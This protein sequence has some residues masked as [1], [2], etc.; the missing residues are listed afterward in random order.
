MSTT[1]ILPSYSD[2]EDVLQSVTTYNPAQVHGLMC[3]LLCTLPEQTNTS[4]EKLLFGNKIPQDHELLIELYEKSFEQ[5]NSFSFDF[6]LLLP[7]EDVDINDR[8]EA[9]GLWCQGFLTGL[10]HGKV[11]LKNREPGDVTETL[12]D[13]LE[14]SQVSYGELTDDNEDETAY[15]ELVEYVRLGALMIFQD[16]KANSPQEQSNQNN[17]LH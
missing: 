2:I 11:P 14:I 15:L 8:V 13:F 6:I 1:P 9:L 10:E 16:L 5:M 7:D 3:G 12:D 17:M 4:W